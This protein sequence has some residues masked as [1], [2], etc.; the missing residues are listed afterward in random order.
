MTVDQPKE[1]LA[2]L[3]KTSDSKKVIDRSAI[4]LIAKTRIPPPP[5]GHSSSDAAKYLEELIRA[6]TAEIIASHSGYGYVRWLWYLRRIPTALFA[7]TYSTTTAYDMALAETLCSSFDKQ[8]TAENPDRIRFKID[9]ST[10][11]HISRLVGAV[12]VLSQLHTAYRCIGKGATLDLTHA[13]PLWHA[14]API[15]DAMRIYD[16]RHD[17]IQT[18]ELRGLGIANASADA[19]SLERGLEAGMV[20][21]MFLFIR[22]SEYRAPVNAPDQHGQLRDQ[23][24]AAS[25]ALSALSLERLLDPYNIAPAISTPAYVA[26]L[27]PLIILLM[28]WPAFAAKMPWTL[29]SALQ[30]GYFFTR[31]SEFRRLFEFWSPDL[32]A[33]LQKSHPSIPWNA[34][35]ASWRARLAALVPS[36]WP[37]RPS[38]AVRE[39]GQALL[40]DVATASSAILTRARS[41]RTQSELANSRAFAFELQVQSII[42]A[43]SWKPSEDLSAVRGRTLR[44]DGK[45]VTDIDAIGFER[46]ALLLVSCKSIIYDDD[47]DRGVFRVVRNVQDTVDNAVANWSK[48]LATL[49]AHPLG[50]NYDFTKVK[51]MV[52]VVCT[53]YVAYTSASETLA[54]VIDGLRACVAASELALWLNRANDAPE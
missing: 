38:T 11:R 43:S 36:Q 3:F 10:V 33:I 25:Y 19:Q 53:P 13:W 4:E 15:R 17:A 48:I 2:R 51:S 41:D 37:L 44:I 54:D 50:D 39:Y 12:R 26:E 30:T 5:P 46:D 7:G 27:E 18:M 28:L 21:E 6:V 52:G 31:E 8:D 9:D 16:S 22:S 47:Y 1:L 29:A 32:V 49:R 14:S 35:Y 45:A 23:T 24:V 40:I 20:K 42:D 34:D